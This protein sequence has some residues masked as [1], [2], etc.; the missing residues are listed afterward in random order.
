MI[1]KIKLLFTLSMIKKMNLLFIF[2][3][4]PTVLIIGCAE[5]EWIIRPVHISS[6]DIPESVNLSESI[7]FKMTCVTPDPC[8]K[9]SHLELKQEDFDVWIKVYAKRDPKAICIQILGSFETSGQFEPKSRGNYQFHF[10]QEYDSKYL[11][12]TVVVK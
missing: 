3:L 10:W 8:Y 1:K 4:I 11:D 12:K 6:V 5:S 7:E 2:C 9:F